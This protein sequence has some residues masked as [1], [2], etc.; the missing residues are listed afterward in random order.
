MK[1]GFDH[2]INEINELYQLILLRLNDYVQI[3]FFPDIYQTLDFIAMQERF[4]SLLAKVENR[5]KLFKIQLFFPKNFAW[6]YDLVWQEDFFYAANKLNKSEIFT[7]QNEQF[8][9]SPRPQPID[10]KA[11]SF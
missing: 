5:P 7:P 1:L 6:E 3:N 9:I 4:Y 2:N 11:V 10:E 8:W